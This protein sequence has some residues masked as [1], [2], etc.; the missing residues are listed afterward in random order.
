MAPQE[1][2]YMQLHG[3]DDADMTI[4]LC[5]H[6]EFRAGTNQLSYTLYNPTDSEDG[7]HFC[8]MGLPTPSGANNHAVPSDWGQDIPGGVI[9]GVKNGGIDHQWFEGTDFTGTTTYGTSW[10]FVKR[11]RYQI[12]LTFNDVNNLPD[13]GTVFYVRYV[14]DQSQ[15]D[16][17]G[18]IWSYTVENQGLQFTLPP[19]KGAMTHITV[20]G[21][22]TDWLGVE[23]DNTWTI[24]EWINH[25]HDIGCLASAAHAWAPS[26]PHTPQQMVSATFDLMEIL[27]SETSGSGDELYDGMLQIQVPLA[28]PFPFLTS[29]DDGSSAGNFQS[30]V[31][32]DTMEKA[33]MIQNFRQGNC[34]ASK[35]SGGTGP[36]GNC[37]ILTPISVNDNDITIGTLFS[38]YG[39]YKYPCDFHWIT[40]NGEVRTT[41]NVIQD[42]FT[43]SGDE[44]YVRLIVNAPQNTTYSNPFIIV[45]YPILAEWEIPTSQIDGLFNIRLGG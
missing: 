33:D 1:S 36:G 24:Q 6:E 32:S 2:Q 9:H 19:V 41:L 12:T 22:E 28:K 29:A 14:V 4:S 35:G 43:V 16:L 27:N 20:A 40:T 7:W 25:L 31:Y 34:F 11:G 18:I 42:T 45:P 8:Y 39:T 37:L 13:P 17:S 5:N 44:G 15:R 10:N 30:V 3:L 38:G 21:D 26:T 23:D